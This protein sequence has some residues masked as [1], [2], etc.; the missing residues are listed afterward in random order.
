MRR[1]KIA[2]SVLIAIAL[3]AVSFTTDAQETKSISYEL[4][5]P[6]P[7]THYFE[8]GMTIN[9]V[10]TN[11]KLLDKRRLLVKMPVWTPGSYLVREYAGNVEAF[12]VTDEN[13]KPLAFR[14][15]NKNTWEIEIDQAED[16]KV[17]YK[18]YA[19]D[20]TVRTSF[21]DASH[22]YL[23]GASI[24]MFVPELMK[25][26]ADLTI[27]PY[28]KWSTV[29]TA[30]PETSKNTFI[31]KDFDTLV[32]SP[33]EIGNHEVLEFEALGIPYRIAM[34]S[35]SPLSYDKEKLLKDYKSLVIAAETV[36]GE[37]PLENY[38]FIVHHQPGI[39]GGLEHLHSTTCQTSTY[40]YSSDRAYIGLFGLLAHEYFH[41]WNVKR[42][43]P[44]ALGPFDYENENYT[45]ML[46]VAEG[47]TSFYEEIILNRAGLVEDEDVIKAVAGAI[48]SA[49]NTPG[50]RVQAVTEAS[51][52]A[53]I[54]YYR[55]SENANNTRISY[56]GKGGVLA[57]LLNA[58]IIANT[59]AEK[60][61]DDVMKLLYNK[62]YKA[63]G[64]GYT[65]EEFQL[66]VEEVHGG[67]L[68]Y[69]FK[70]YISGTERPDYEQI[71]KGVGLNLID[72]NEDREKPYLGITERGGVIYRMSREGSAYHSGINLNDQVVSIDGDKNINFANATLSKKVGD[73]MSVIVNR[74]GVEM[75]F[76]IDLQ[77]DA[78]KSYSL[79]KVSKPTKEQEKAYQ[80]FVGK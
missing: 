68:D 10:L 8:V 22:G 45:N 32:D 65:D 11:S 14:K 74:H 9:N 72:T 15:V 63:L 1:R 21:I 46:W 25:S 16:V 47:F 6:E 60:S 23:N 49:E 62:Y 39:G 76:I 33:I 28:E 42:I 13:N 34:Y 35:S 54:K 36:V 48:S 29:S 55:P 69:F 12:K 66:A 3:Y 73:K 57:A 50:N 40:A 78:R 4:R 56:Y 20:L 17:S 5:M 64:R 30:L 51:W 7:E 70:N 26:Q 80:K 75:E 38:L 53:W 52:D 31:V 19:F 71:Y 67:D 43:R 41:L 44:V 58:K 18:V 2:F 24:F 61:L 77:E 37:T 59:K 79:E 27:F